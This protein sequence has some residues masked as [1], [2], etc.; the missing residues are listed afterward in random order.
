MIGYREE[1]KARQRESN[2]GEHRLAEVKAVSGTKATLQ[3]E[4]EDDTSGKLYRTTVA[5]A[6]GD[7]VL[8]ARASG[9]YVIIG[10]L[11]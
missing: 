8:C 2:V 10:V 1:M 7:R 11:K 5:V 6:A 9:T 4:G 3:F